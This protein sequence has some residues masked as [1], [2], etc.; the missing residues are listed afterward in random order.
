[1]AVRDRFA[2]GEFLEIFMDT[3]LDVCMARDP[4]GLYAKAKSGSL[5]NFT[6][7]SSPFETP[8]RPDLRLDGTLPPED[9]AQQVV[10]F[11]ESR[12]AD[13]MKAGAQP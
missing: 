4:K 8:E 2:D 13:A 11:L 6:G 7:I 9:L 3:P 1:M 12:E 10:A 5:P